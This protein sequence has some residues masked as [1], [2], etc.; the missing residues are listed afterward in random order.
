MPLGK[1]QRTTLKSLAYH[2]SWPGG[3]VWENTSSTVRILD[4]LVK[5]G[6]VDM[7]PPRPMT[8]QGGRKLKYPVTRA[9]GTY[10]IN[11]AGREAIA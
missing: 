7:D 10:R 11:D 5:R 8:H 6:L 4:S 9:Y 2:G 1:N 3:W